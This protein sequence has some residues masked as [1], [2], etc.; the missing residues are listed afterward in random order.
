MLN[1]IFEWLLR[2]GD[3]VSGLGLLLFTAFLV[4]L[5]RQQKTLL[6][7]SYKTTHKAKIE[8]DFQYTGGEDELYL[9]LSNVGNGVATDLDLVIL[10][11]YTDADG[12]VQ[13]GILTK[14]LYRLDR[15]DAY[16]R[17]SLEA[18]EREIEYRAR[19]SFPS[20]DG[21]DHTFPSGLQKIKDKES[22]DV[23]RLHIYVRYF[24]LT[25]D[26]QLTY[27]GGWEYT[28][29]EE[30]EGIREFFDHASKMLIRED[31]WEAPDIY[32]ETLAYDLSGTPI[33]TG[34]TVI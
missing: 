18:R 7:R 19:L 12:T 30:T 25:D 13:D 29:D 6:S 33:E 16:T 31:I 11:I 32:P 17:G 24:D 3:V 5:Y 1:P 23:V 14:P 9:D 20:L 27:L 34:R 28:P 4:I 15:G 22:L 10:G 26:A 21:I 2:W 8:V